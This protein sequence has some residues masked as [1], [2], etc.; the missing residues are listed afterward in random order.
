MIMIY[1]ILIIYNK[2]NKNKVLI[3]NHHIK[4]AP[5]T[6]YR[7]L[8]IQ[9]NNLFLKKTHYMNQKSIYMKNL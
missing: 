2:L 4:V 7:N 8:K 1:P 5:K 9:L 6:I 3:K